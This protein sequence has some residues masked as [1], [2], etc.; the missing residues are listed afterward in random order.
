[1]KRKV[2]IDNQTWVYSI[3]PKFG[4]PWEKYIL[5]NIYSQINNYLDG[6]LNIKMVFKLHHR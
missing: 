5:V 4:D 6:I 1:M 3:I 2:H